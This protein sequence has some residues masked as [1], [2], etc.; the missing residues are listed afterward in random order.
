MNKTVGISLGVLVVVILV[1]VGEHQ[2]LRGLADQRE[3]L[4]QFGDAFGALNTLFSGLAFS[5]LILTLWMQRE[6][7]TLQRTELI[8]SRKAQQGSREALAGC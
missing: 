4:G 6:E 8:E 2:Y 1:Y 5:A 7:L 3:E